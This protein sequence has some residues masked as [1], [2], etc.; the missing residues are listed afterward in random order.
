MITVVLVAIPVLEA[1][2]EGKEIVYT[3]PENHDLKIGQKTNMMIDWARRYSL[4]RL[5]FAAELV[6]E[7]V[8][9]RFPGINKIGA[10]I[11]QEKARID[12]Q[13]EEPIS[14]HLPSLQKEAQTIIDSDQQIISAFS[15]FC[16]VYKFNVTPRNEN[17]FKALWHTATLEV[18]SHNKSVGSRLHK[19]VGKENQ[20]IA[21]SQWPSREK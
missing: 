14:P 10:H 19:V 17:E 12:F 16:A 2:K 9:R 5:H 3:L 7:L 4:M 21:Y 15:M 8:S 18:K 20:W 1:K 11:G 6:L 13:I